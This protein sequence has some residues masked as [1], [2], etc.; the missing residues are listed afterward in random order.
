MCPEELHPSLGELEVE[1]RVLGAQV[2]ELPDSAG[3]G[4]GREEAR[5]GEEEAALPLAAAAH[6][7]AALKARDGIRRRERR[8]R[9]WRVGAL[10]EAVGE[11]ERAEA[12]SLVGLGVGERRRGRGL[13]DHPPVLLVC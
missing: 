8:P 12:S 9:R 6:D 4:G 2:G 13:L 7:V 10:E 5:E 1:H 11:G 3:R